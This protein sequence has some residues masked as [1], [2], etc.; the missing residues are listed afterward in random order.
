MKMKKLL[1][2]LLLISFLAVSGCGKKD[3]KTDKTDKTDDKKTENVKKDD[4][5]VDKKDDKSSSMNDLQMTEGLPK[6][7]P[8]DIP[9][10]RNS[11]CL[12]S[13]SSSDGT[14]VSFESTDNVKYVVDFYKEEMKK[15]G[16]D[17]QEGADVLVSETAAILGWKKKDRD[18]SVIIGY[19][20]DKSVSQITVTYK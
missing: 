7:Y 12:G 17:I 5:N 10:P 20:K 19:D 8:G 6:N 4:Q 9:Q 15:N 18:V 11:K 1:L 13:F 3:D 16:F 14:V 2:L